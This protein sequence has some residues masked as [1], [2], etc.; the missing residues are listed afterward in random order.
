MAELADAQD[1]G[2][3]T[4]SVWVRVP[5]TAVRNE[6]SLKNFIICPKVFS[7]HSEISNSS[8][9]RLR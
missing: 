3:C 1:L 7:K 8:G 2:S 4:L 5:L 9:K 6:K